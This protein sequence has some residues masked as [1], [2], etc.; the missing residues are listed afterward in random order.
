MGRWA[1]TKMFDFAT[2]RIVLVGP[3]PPPSGGMAN[4][5]EQLGRLLSEE[6]ARVRIVQTNAPYRPPAVRRLR[7]VRALFRFV[8]YVRKLR[9]SMREAT[10]VHIMANSGW[11]WHL[12]AAPALRVAH[13]AGVPITLHYHGGDAEKFFARSFRKVENSLRLA[14]AVAVPSKFLEG[15][16]REVGVRVSVVPNIVDLE[17]F[18][19]RLPRVENGRG[20]RILIARNLEPIYDIE[21]GLRAFARLRQTCSRATLDVA[22]S[23]PEKGRLE[24]LAAELELGDAAR[25]LGRIP[26]EEMPRLYAQAD[27]ALNTSLVDNMPI[28]VLEA[29]ASGVPVVSTRVGG[30]PALVGDGKEAVL[31]APGEPREMAL[32]LESLWKTPAQREAL[33]L[34][35]LEKAKHFGWASVREQW[36]RIYEDLEP[37]RK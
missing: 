6:G 8:P 34:A 30:V 12:I 33:R 28:S 21:T 32:A 14:D 17:R 18:H 35:G 37:G 20:P 23:G 2:A 24:A 13:G 5:T 9:R 31:V 15:V 29:F 11:A 4:Q 27:I 10:I 7:G 3:L 16:F 1:H 25:F 36:A 22:G 26:N 19:A